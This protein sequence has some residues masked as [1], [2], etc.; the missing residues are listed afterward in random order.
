MAKGLGTP[1]YE[2]GT[3]IRDKKTKTDYVIQSSV[4]T[5]ET[6][7]AL[8]Y[9]IY[10]HNKNL[11]TV[12]VTSTSHFEEI[13]TTLRT[14]PSG[15]TPEQAMKIAEEDTKRC[16]PPENVEAIIGIEEQQPLQDLFHMIGSID[17]DR[18]ARVSK[19]LV[20][21]ARELVMGFDLTSYER[22]DPGY[23]RALLLE[24]VSK[25]ITPEY[26]EE[27]IK[28]YSSERLRNSKVPHSRA[29]Q[30]FI[31]ALLT[32]GGAFQGLVKAR[33]VGLFD[34]TK[35]HMP[36]NKTVTGEWSPMKSLFKSFF[37]GNLGEY[38]PGVSTDPTARTAQ[39][40][41][42]AL[43]PH[44]THL[45][46]SAREAA[47]RLQARVKKGKSTRGG[48]RLLNHTLSE[49]TEKHGIHDLLIRVRDNIVSRRMGAYGQ[50]ANTT[51]NR[52]SS[53]RFSN[54]FYRNAKPFN[55]I[56]ETDSLVAANPEYLMDLLRGKKV[57]Y[58]GEVSTVNKGLM[59]RIL[60]THQD[61]RLFIPAET[62]NNIV[63]DDK[64][65]DLDSAFQ[66]HQENKRDLLKEVDLS[67]SNY[68]IR[69]RE[70]VPT[71]FDQ[72]DESYFRFRGPNKNEISS[73]S[74]SDILN[75]APEGVQIF[76][77]S[78]D[79]N[80]INIKTL[81]TKAEILNKNKALE[82]ASVIHTGNWH[83]PSFPAEVFEEA[84]LS[85]SIAFKSVK[86]TP[87]VFGSDLDLPL[88][89]QLALAK[90]Y[91]SN[92]ESSA[93][94]DLETIS[95]NGLPFI[96]QANLATA[97]N[98]IFDHVGQKRVRFNEA[99]LNKFEELIHHMSGFE[100][101]G[102]KGNFDLETMLQQL[103]I[104]DD[105]L[106]DHRDRIA[107][108]RHELTDIYHNRL[109]NI[110]IIPQLAGHRLGNLRQETLA[111]DELN[112]PLSQL[113]HQHEAKYDVQQAHELLA[114]MKS[115]FL[116]NVDELK[117]VQSMVY[118]DENPISRTYGMIIKNH[119][120]YTH[121]SH[122]SALLEEMKLDGGLKGTGNYINLSGLSASHLGA[123]LTNGAT[124]W[125]DDLI[126]R[127]NEINQDVGA[128][129]LRGLNPFNK[130]F[131][132]PTGEWDREMINEFGPHTVFN[133]HADRKAQALLPE[134]QRK[135]ASHPLPT[136]PLERQDAIERFASDFLLSKGI[137]EGP[138]HK[139]L[140]YKLADAIPGTQAHKALT[141][142]E[143][144]QF[145]GS[146]YGEMLAKVSSD[147]ENEIS[148]VLGYFDGFSRLMQ[149]LKDGGFEKEITTVPRITL[150][151][152]GKAVEGLG[153]TS[154]GL[155]TSVQLGPK[156]LLDGVRELTN[157]VIAENNKVDYRFF[158][159]S[160]EE[161]DKLHEASTTLA[162]ERGFGSNLKAWKDAIAD[163][164]WDYTDN[165]HIKTIRQLQQKISTSE[166]MESL[167]AEAVHSGQNESINNRIAGTGNKRI[168]QYFNAARN[169]APGALDHIFGKRSEEEISNYAQKI[170][171]IE[172]SSIV[173]NDAAFANESEQGIM[174]NRRRFENNLE[175]KI[176]DIWENVRNH[177]Q[178]NRDNG[179]TGL[180][181]FTGIEQHLHIEEAA[182]Q[183]VEA[184]MHQAGIPKGEN[185][186]QVTTAVNLT[187]KTIQE[188]I[189]KK[190][191]ATMISQSRIEAPLGSAKFAKPLMA[192]SAAIAL[193][194]G[195]NPKPDFS[196]GKTS[197]KT[198]IDPIIKNSE[199]PGDP[200]KMAVWNGSTDPFRIDIT[201]EGFVESKRHQEELVRNV[202]NMFDSEFDIRNNY[203]YIEDNRNR[204]HRTTAR[205]IM[206]KG[207]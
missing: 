64:V 128:R 71:Q 50:I 141:S 4:A 5:T 113:R 100:V 84:R 72:N 196:Q 28:A 92:P 89:H 86:D 178:Q 156:A 142:S 127:Y 135:L 98:Q 40:Y 147:P 151:L 145:L 45:G 190:L 49:T 21:L 37:G 116:E 112:T 201:F 38:H 17:P 198:G 121:G 24:N 55:R 199:I 109:F 8:L 120:V 6:G 146:K 192:L 162:G 56:A 82:Q 34:H 19:E 31:E 18:S 165:P 115:R 149:R 102:T 99:Y 194:A 124:P 77:H 16:I 66:F 122:F 75:Q 12:N 200:D 80:E 93:I 78:V 103:D 180:E 95:A 69:R 9:L 2:P 3:L 101:I 114:K 157:K 172:Y 125:T 41:M 189:G 52:S 164:G 63:F 58:K 166:G 22:A 104:M 158:G 197:R 81:G 14:N 132:D 118:L 110:E 60:K 88:D 133:F 184:A 188:D 143:Y 79:G 137:E 191:Q 27:F 123:K 186:K 83:K 204:D 20:D 152:A 76:A 62:F 176:G 42:E 205:D 138:Q 30:T 108:L 167:V 36:S 140:T 73:K 90:K 195:I 105:G 65:V 39:A 181:L 23:L 51:Y 67:G 25:E 85:T 29:P 117:D 59:E 160:E 119:G 91:Y 47:I 193:S 179:A 161:A 207:I 48:N 97:D 57:R 94:L 174:A 169:G 202:Y 206:R 134:Y 136:H 175:A 7:A 46:K 177:I 13:F 1:N 10:L 185:V 171:A 54:L 53:V 35:A 43:G 106:I 74:L 32:D 44:A 182:R 68:E 154:G 96:H 187:T 11:T 33:S 126:E 61:R 139:L 15:N 111:L 131:Q 148:S 163:M 144:G 155:N 183:T 173:L 107:L 203:T 150:G 159:L 87:F 129:K 130:T 26:V 70:F 153:V 168:K 170:Q